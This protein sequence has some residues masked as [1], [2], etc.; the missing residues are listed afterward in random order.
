MCAGKKTIVGLGSMI[1]ECP[2]CH[3]VGHVKI[4]EIIDNKDEEM[5]NVEEIKPIRNKTKRA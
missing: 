3:G 4:D 1:K 2:S 5:N